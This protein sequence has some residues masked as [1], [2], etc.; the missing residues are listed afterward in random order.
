ME[1]ITLGQIG[2]TIACIVAFITGVKYL[3]GEIKTIIEKAFEPTNK[4]IDD[5]E[6]RLTE[7]IKKSD[8]N[9]TK[10]FLVARIHEMKAGEE[11]DD[12]SR[13]RFYEEYEHYKQL[14]GNGFLTSEIKKLG[15]F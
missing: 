7:E 8:L 2:A 13:E 12:I 5:M 3:I 1:Q 15:L 9:A 10:N 6:K 11:L 14:G 4:K